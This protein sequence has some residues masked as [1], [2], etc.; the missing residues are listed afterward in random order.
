MDRNTQVW[1][2]GGFVALVIVAVV[3]A[4]LASKGGEPASNFVGT[5]TTP[6]DASDHVKG[7]ASSSVSVIE[8]G[9]FECPACG[10]WEPAFEQLETT[11]GTRVKFIFRNFPLTQL[12]PNAMIAAQAAE[13]ANLQGKYWQMHDLLYQKQNEWT[14]TPNDQVV[15]KNF[16]GYAHSL[17]LDVAKFNADINSAAVKARIQRDVDSGNAAQV[18]HTPTFFVNLQQIQNPNSP[19]QFAQVLDQ[20]LASS[21]AK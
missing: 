4:T 17:G 18:N 20:E 5:T 19:Q 8:Y 11:Y 16:D 12:H 13:A 2:I 21:T 14:N 3:A 10:A 15:A 7:D 1:I 9:D 6:L